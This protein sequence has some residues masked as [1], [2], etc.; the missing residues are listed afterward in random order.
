MRTPRIL[1][2]GGMNADILGVCE[3]SY[4]AGD[5]IPGSISTRPGGVGRNVA[6]ALAARGVEVELLTAIGTDVHAAALEESC[7]ELGIGLTLSATIPGPSPAYLAIHDAQG[8]MRAAVNDM[9][10]L[11]SLTPGYLQGVSDRLRD[12][13]VCVLDANLPEETL[14]AAAELIQAPLV[15]DPV[16]AVKAVRLIPVVPRLAAIKPNL[17]EAQA[18]AGV[19]DMEKAARWLMKQGACRV[20]ISLG[21]EGLYWADANNCGIIR[22]SSLFMSCETGAGDA[23][24]AG[25]TYGLA[26]G[27]STIQTARLGLQW[28]EAHMGKTDNNKR[29]AI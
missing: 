11:D 24:T 13:D 1:V 10:P 22:P 27:L 6:A 18:L 5:S 12:F 4:L 23:V 29:G 25:I 15:A 16:S 9:R 19:T 2:I 3:G 14:R 26:L 20:F 7:R 17:M 28:A 8:K 21:S